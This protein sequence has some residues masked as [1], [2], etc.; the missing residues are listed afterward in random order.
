MVT[1]CGGLQAWKVECME[2]VEKNSHGMAFWQGDHALH[3]IS[4][5]GTAPAY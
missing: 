1:Y 4:E 3:C 5:W 2:E